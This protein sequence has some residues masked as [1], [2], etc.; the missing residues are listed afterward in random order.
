MA[1]IIR[2]VLG[3]IAPADLGVTMTHEHLLL[4]FGRWQRE[5]AERGEGSAPTPRLTTDDPRAAEPLSLNNIGWSR[6]NWAMHPANLR[7]DDEDLAIAEIRLFKEAGGN[8]IVDATNPDLYRQPDALVRIAQ[9]VDLHIVMGA[10]HYI[11]DFHP[12]DMDDRDEESIATEIVADVTAGCDGTTVRAGVIGEIGCSWP[13]TKN[14]RR[15]LRASARAQAATGAAL[16]IHPGR[17]PRSPFQIMEIVDEAG[18]DA[19]RTIMS[20][21]DRTIFENDDLARLGAT[22]CYLEFDLFGQE[23]SHYPFS[24]VD[25]PNDATRVDHLRFLIAEGFGGRLL[26]AQDICRQTSL[27]SSGGDGYAHILANVVP[28]MQRKGMSQAEIDDIL[29]HNPACVLAFEPV[30]GPA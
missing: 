3:D 19:A 10:G 9:S 20:H 14:E 13:L 28:L 21:L 24:A 27:A 30:G 1:S 2:T 23:S 8:A 15:A 26:V 5:A 7:L 16:L 25:M 22:G 12:P 29:I 18:G 17:S 6:R 4:E 11:A